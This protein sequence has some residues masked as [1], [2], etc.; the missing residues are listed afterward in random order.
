MIQSGSIFR[1]K[2]R[3]NVR[4]DTKF[5]RLINKTVLATWEKEWRTKRAAR[6]RAPPLAHTFHSIPLIE[7]R[8]SRLQCAAY[9]ITFI[10]I[11]LPSIKNCTATLGHHWLI[12]RHR[13]LSLLSY[14]IAVFDRWTFDHKTLQEYKLELKWI[15]YR[16]ISSV[17]NKR[18]LTI[19]FEKCKKQYLKISLHRESILIPKLRMLLAVRT[20]ATGCDDQLSFYGEVQ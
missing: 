3:F 18:R 15:N 1:C 17:W 13:K 2:I 4:L 20:K 6:E 5:K 10:N 19:S 9:N 12:L 7:E 11:M 16:Y 8:A 14:N